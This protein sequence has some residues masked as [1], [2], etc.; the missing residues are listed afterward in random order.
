MAQDCSEPAKEALQKIRQKALS[1]LARREHSSLELEQKL[2][3]KDY[4][5]ELIHHVLIDFQKRN[6]LSDSR[7]AEIYIRKRYFDGY[8]ET[9]IRQ[10]LKLRGIDNPEKSL[11]EQPE[12]DWF[13]SVVSVYQ[14]KYKH[15]IANDRKELAKR[16]R[17]LQ[18][19][20]FNFE[21]IAFAMQQANKI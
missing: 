14:K 7:F 5:P 21:Q 8:G 12:F 1:L 20:G 18:Y 2:S 15:N 3:Q 17:F 6:W 10:E 11:F 19:R 16:Q 9:R 4:S 13:E